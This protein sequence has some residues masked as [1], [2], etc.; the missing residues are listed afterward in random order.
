MSGYAYVRNGS[1]GDLAIRHALVRSTPQTGH[2][3]ARHAGQ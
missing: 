3:R 2:L 1:T